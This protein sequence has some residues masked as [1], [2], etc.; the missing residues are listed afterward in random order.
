MEV[1]HTHIQIIIC[2]LVTILQNKLHTTIHSKIDTGHYLAWHLAL[3]GQDKDWFAQ[4]R[5]T[6]TVWNIGG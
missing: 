3:L 1:M 5:D 6:V 2:Y 4:Y